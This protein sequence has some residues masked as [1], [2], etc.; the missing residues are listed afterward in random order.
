MKEALSARQPWWR[1]R[2]VGAFALAMLVQ[3]VGAVTFGRILPSPW[4]DGVPVVLGFAVFATYHPDWWRTPW[5]RGTLVQ[6]GVL[7]ALG[8]AVV[9]LDSRLDWQP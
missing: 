5:R 7:V 9:A 8:L 3:L 6:L 1:R 4:R 2:A